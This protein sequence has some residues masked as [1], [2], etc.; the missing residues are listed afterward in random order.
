MQ[1]LFTI[2]RKDYDE[3]WAHSKR[4]SIRAVIFK[5]DKLAMVYSVRD[6]YYKFPGGGM[7]EHEEHHSTLIREVKEE[8]GLNVIP[9]SI[10]E[11]GEVVVLRKSDIFENTVFEQESF[12]YFCDTEEAAGDQH[13]DDYEADAGF[14]LRY[15]SI[16]E[17]IRVND[18][19][20]IAKHIDMLER[21]SSVLKLL[22]ERNQ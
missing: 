4:P 18:M 16:E 3:A 8:V 15:V 13:L 12:Y 22:V 19:N 17:A 5:G 20:T 2:D 7:E 1:L 6:K 9:S 11:F 10:K 21:E 14:E